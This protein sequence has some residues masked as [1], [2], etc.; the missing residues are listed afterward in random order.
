MA[1]ESQIAP[2]S[3]P[4]CPAHNPKVAGSNPA[5]AIGK[6]PQIAEFFRWTG[7]SRIW[8]SYQFL[9]AEDE[10]RH[11]RKC[12]R[13]WTLEHRPV[14]QGPQTRPVRTCGHVFLFVQ[15]SWEG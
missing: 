9:G 1:L 10:H 11:G 4:L 13:P 5:P 7:Q 12:D 2:T 6:A 3:N 15:A 8:N 14:T